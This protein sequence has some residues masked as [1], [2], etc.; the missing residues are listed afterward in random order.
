MYGRNDKTSSC[1]E[2]RVTKVGHPIVFRCTKTCTVPEKYG[3]K[4]DN[5]KFILWDNET[6][7][8]TKDE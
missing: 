1:I 7:I 4:W 3:W 6:E 5:G 2:V 8:L